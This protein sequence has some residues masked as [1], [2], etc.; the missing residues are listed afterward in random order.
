VWTWLHSLLFV[1]HFPE[2]IL[3]IHNDQLILDEEG[4]KHRG[5]LTRAKAEDASAPSDD[6]RKKIINS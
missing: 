2:K 1:V 5:A 3:L 6:V 4:M